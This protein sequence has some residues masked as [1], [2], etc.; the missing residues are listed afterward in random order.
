M[1]INYDKLNC[2]V[3]DGGA[4][5]CR[6]SSYHDSTYLMNGEKLGNNKLLGRKRPSFTSSM[7]LSK[8]KSQFH[9]PQGTHTT[10][11]GH[12]D[13]ISLGFLERLDLDLDF[14]LACATKC[15]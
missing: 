12:V 8:L 11:C 13:V 7:L 6:K 1:S 5:I 4:Q 15:M 9:V 3:I 2:G 14:D 10:L